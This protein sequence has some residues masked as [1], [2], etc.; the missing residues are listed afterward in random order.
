MIFG[1]ISVLL[2]ASAQ[3]VLKKAT[4]LNSIT[5]L[6]FFK[7]PFLYLTGILYLLSIIFWFLA[8]SKLSLTVAYPLQALGYALVCIAAIYLFRDSMTMMNWLGILLIL[9]GVVLTQV[10]KQ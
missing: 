9:S 4:Q 5:I 8:L 2:N 10:G 3:I 7:N 6:D 1:L